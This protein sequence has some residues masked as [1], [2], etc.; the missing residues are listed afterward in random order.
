MASYEGRTSMIRL[1]WCYEL[2]NSAI[3]NCKVRKQ[4]ICECEHSDMKIVPDS[5]LRG[6][7]I[8]F[9][10]FLWISGLVPPSVISVCFPVPHV[11]AGVHK[12]WFVPKPD[13][14]CSVDTSSLIW[15]NQSV[16]ANH[17][18]CMYSRFVFWH[19]GHCWM[20]IVMLLN[21]CVVSDG[22]FC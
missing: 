10:S 13:C 2:K 11:G 3:L 9:E 19:Q 14:H 5:L 18:D 22:L 4:K 1:T 16:A 21:V 15:E 6:S 20:L 7:M 8:H 17:W 12:C